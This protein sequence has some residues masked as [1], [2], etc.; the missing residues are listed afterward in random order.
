M[1]HQPMHG[2]RPEMAMPFYTN[3]RP[4]YQ[5]GPPVQH[6]GGRQVPATQNYYNSR[7][8]Q[9]SWQ[10]LPPSR[11]PQ[12][13]GTQSSHHSQRPHGGYAPTKAG[14]VFAAD[15]TNNLPIHRQQVSFNPMITSG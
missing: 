7:N 15:R 2:Y 9:T 6:M 14:M 1:H 10:E 13:M 3:R 11:D 5:H 8:Q 4:M 12:K